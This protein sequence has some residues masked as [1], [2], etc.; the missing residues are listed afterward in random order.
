VTLNQLQASPIWVSGPSWLP[1]RS[2]WPQ[3][4]SSGF[5][6]AQILRLYA[7]PPDPA[8]VP[9]LDIANIIDITRFNWT[10]Q[11]ARVFRQSTNFLQKTPSWIS[12]PLTTKELLNGQIQ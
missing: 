10:S 1:D 5:K 6:P 4:E 12:G 3:S 2:A 7:I 11:T 8:P 9:F